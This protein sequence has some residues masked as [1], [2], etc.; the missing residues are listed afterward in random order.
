M[1]AMTNC[2]ETACAATPQATADSVTYDAPIVSLWRDPNAFFA[3]QTPYGEFHYIGSATVSSDDGRQLLRLH[4]PD[5][6]LLKAIFL[7]A[8]GN[9]VRIRVSTVAKGVLVGIDDVSA[10]LEPLSP[11][12]PA[13]SAP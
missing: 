4:D 1:L 2:I 8:D 12:A 5:T 6:A 10:T 3:I 9:P 13:K 7:A 11:A